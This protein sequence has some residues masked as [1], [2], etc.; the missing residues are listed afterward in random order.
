MSKQI[1]FVLTGLILTLSSVGCCCLGGGYGYGANRCAPCGPAP[2]GGGCPTSGGGYY[3]PQ[4]GAYY[5]GLDAN[6]TAFVS[7]PTQTA[8]VPS[9]AIIGAPIMASPGNYTTTTL[10]PNSL[11]TY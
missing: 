3:P 4:Q 2:C 7:G 6:Q 5:Q 1:A 9:S 8:I 11:P 10:I